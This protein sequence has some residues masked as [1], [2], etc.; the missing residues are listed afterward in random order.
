MHVLYCVV[1]NISINVLYITKK[2][3][4][5]LLMP[6]VILMENIQMYIGSIWTK[7]DVCFVVLKKNDFFLY[8]FSFILYIKK[9]KVVCGVQES[10]SE[11][12]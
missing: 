5:R 3:N 11:K 6:N 4:M 12:Y 7:T 10:I 8:W 9:G 2:K 1:I